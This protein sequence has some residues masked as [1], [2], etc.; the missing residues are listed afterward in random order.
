MEG[1][2]SYVVELA[3]VVLQICLQEVYPEQGEPD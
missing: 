2:D 3:A 1:D